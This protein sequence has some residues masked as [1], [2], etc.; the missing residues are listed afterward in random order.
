MTNLKVQCYSG[1]KADEKLIS[2]VLDGN[3]RM[4]E[5]IIDQW[6]NPEFD[7]FRVMG[8]DRNSFPFR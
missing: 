1:Y 6:R 4:V 5:K 7:Y 2:F 8:G 3:K